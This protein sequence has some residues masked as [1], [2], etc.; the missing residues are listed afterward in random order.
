MQQAIILIPV[1]PILHA[2]TTAAWDLGADPTCKPGTGS[3][4]SGV[5]GSGVAVCCREGLVRN[6]EFYVFS[7][8]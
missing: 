1:I 2:I 4:G 5:Q 6:I 7:S 3:H 8:I